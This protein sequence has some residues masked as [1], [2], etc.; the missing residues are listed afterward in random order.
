MKIK[1][2][3][4]KVLV[5]G[6]TGRTG[7][8]IVRRLQAHGINHRIFVRS[9]TKALEMFGPDYAGRLVEGTIENPAD[10]EAAVAGCDAVISAIGAYV[11]DPDAPPPSVIDRDGMKAFAAIAKRFGVKK[12][13]QVTSLAVTK[14]EHPMNKYGGVLNMKFQGENAIRSTYSDP[15]FSYTIIRPGGLQDG[16]PLQHLLEFGTDDTIMGVIDRSDLAEAAVVSLWHPK[17]ANRT[18]ELIRGEAAVQESLDPFFE[19]LS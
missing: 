9:S 13:I 3:E 7:Q 8:W 12:F 10:L 15:G 5:A 1:Q 6:A 17:A 16:E 18:F 19:Q 4:G 11:T 2:F 14:P